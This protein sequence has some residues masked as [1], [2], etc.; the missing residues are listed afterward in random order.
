MNCRYFIVSAFV[1]ASLATG[2][3]A[4][5]EKNSFLE[6]PVK[7][8]A[9]LVM[10]IRKDAHVRDRYMRHFG[11]TVDQLTSEFSKLHLGKLS[12]AGEYLVYN[13]DDLGVVHSK[14]LH[15]KAGTPV[16]MDASG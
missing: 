5:T 4:R 8:V 10:Q 3:F 7:S 16:F 13:I 11:K 1:G 15:L 14:M 2:A 9:D 12:S 6:R